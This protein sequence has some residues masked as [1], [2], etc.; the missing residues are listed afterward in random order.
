[1]IE[2]HIHLTDDDVK[3]VLD[4]INAGRVRDLPGVPYDPMMWDKEAVRDWLE[5][6]HLPRRARQTLYELRAGKYVKSRPHASTVRMAVHGL[7]A[8]IAQLEQD[9]A[10]MKQ[11]IA[12][13]A[14]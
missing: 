11:S 5:R 8:R 3:V 14:R 10:E 7:E 4:A 2:G 12:D 6:T 9:V 13:R 1:M